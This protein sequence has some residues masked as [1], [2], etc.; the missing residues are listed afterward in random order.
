MIKEERRMMEAVRAELNA[1]GTVEGAGH[2]TT[3]GNCICGQKN[4]VSWSSQT[5]KVVVMKKVTVS[6]GRDTRT[7][8][9][10]EVL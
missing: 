7:F 2:H 6:Q 10:K 3:A 9:R 5:R 8:H 1:D 4:T